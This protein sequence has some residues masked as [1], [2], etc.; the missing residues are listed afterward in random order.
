MNR[1]NR[2][3]VYRVAMVVTLVAGA[4]VSVYEVFGCHPAR[5]EAAMIRL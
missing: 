2:S 5:D 3:A 1:L 4:A